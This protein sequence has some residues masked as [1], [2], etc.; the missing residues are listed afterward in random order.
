M[1]GSDLIDLGIF[2]YVAYCVGKRGICLVFEKSKNIIG[3]NVS[4]EDS[5]ALK[6]NILDSLCSKD[7][8][9][10]TKL[11]LRYTQNRFHMTSADVFEMFSKQENSVSNIFLPA[12][13][14][15]SELSPSEALVVY[16]KD[17]FGF[18]L[19][20][21]AKLV[22]RDERSLWGNY[23]R[24]KSKGELHIEKTSYLIPLEIFKDRSLSVLEHVVLYLKEN[25]NLNIQT[26]SKLLKKQSTTIWS[27]FNR[28]KQ[29]SKTEDIE[30]E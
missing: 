30:N 17:N 29:K 22:D 2:Q 16:L 7:A 9:S 28:I 25:Y 24:A 4:H 12:T 8:L 19:S 3:P 15:S 21:I 27:V 1:L 5:E 26:I 18:K 20:E 6:F 14:F 11:I 23:N 10:L 13:L